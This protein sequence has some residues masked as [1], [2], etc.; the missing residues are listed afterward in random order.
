M[1]T[2]LLT[3]IEK[4]P[5]ADSHTHVPL[6]AEI[7]ERFKKDKAFHYDVTYL[8]GAATYVAEFIY[9]NNWPELKERLKVNAQH[10]YYRP[11]VLAMRDLYGLPPNAELDDSNVVEIS[12]KMDAAQRDPNWYDEVLK[13]GNIRHILWMNWNGHDLHRLPANQLKDVSIH[14]AWNVD[15]VCYFDGKKP[16]NGEPRELEKV[17]QAFGRKPKD[18][19]DLEN[20]HDESLKRFLANGGV[21]LKSTSAYFRPLDFDDTVPREKAAAAF[22]KVVAQ[23]PLTDKEQR[24]LQDYL[25]VRFIKLAAARKLPFQF[26]TG[27]QQTWN[28]VEDSSPLKLNRLLYS[29]KYAA[30][31][32][33][34]LHG[35]Y[36]YTQE[37]IMLARYFPGTVYLDLAW[38]ALFSPAAF[39]QTLSQALDMLDGSQILIG[40]DTANLEELYGTVKITRRVL[41]E[42][43]AEKVQSGFWTEAVALQVARRVLYTNAVELYWLD[44][45]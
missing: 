25:L 37:S 10:A 3:E 35:G 27:N 36:P 6:P 39:K 33:V 44:K 34:L 21:C 23:K 9:G 2:R 5:Y 38:M 1:L 13:R 45:G 24:L 16:K 7:Q 40:T 20:L 41:A 26:H 19:T 4:I 32:F 11:M 17:E 43:L 18:L 30:A 22:A 12:R 29:G 31:K 28:I 8:L 42:V 14:A 15:W